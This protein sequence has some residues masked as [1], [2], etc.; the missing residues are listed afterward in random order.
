[1]RSM[2]RQALGGRLA[3]SSVGA[4]LLALGWAALAGPVAAHGPVPTDPPSAANL[5][6]GWTFPPLPTL[7]ILVSVVWWLWAVRRVNATHPDH[8]VPRRRTVAFLG[9][10]LALGFALCSGIEAYDTTLFS[11]HMVQHVLLMLVAAP[12]IALS[13][14]VTLLLRLSAPATRQR[15]ILPGPA[16]ARDP[17][18]RLPGRRLGDLRR[19]DVGDPLLAAVQ[20]GARGPVDPRLRARAVP[21]RGVPV[22]VAGGRARSR[23]VAD[24]PPGP[25]RLRVPADDPEHVPGRCDPERDGRPVSPITRRSSGRGASRPSTISGW[26]PGSC[27]SR[28]I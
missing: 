19:D 5:L 11:L 1:M 22:L 6:L 23:A 24:D 28:A 14:P 13:A 10:M 3:R 27:G 26:P 20:R 16:L 21:V 4:T 17:G 18:A 15:W 9:G 7:A 12:L 25:D 2:A 8:P